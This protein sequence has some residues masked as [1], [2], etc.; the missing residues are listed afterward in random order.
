MPG[1]SVEGGERAS[2]E[3]PRGG[4]AAACE[5]DDVVA[6]RPGVLEDLLLGAL[7]GGPGDLVEA[8]HRLRT[9]GRRQAQVVAHGRRRVPMPAPLLAMVTTSMVAPSASLGQS[10]P[11]GW[12]TGVNEDVDRSR[13]SELQRGPAPWSVGPRSR[14]L[15]EGAAQENEPTVCPGSVRPQKRRRGRSRPRNRLSSDLVSEE[16]RPSLERALRQR[17]SPPASGPDRYA[18]LEVLLE[19]SVE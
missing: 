10:L 8:G 3:C 2:R 12:R 5:R 13:Q 4:S 6:R 14:R 19:V 1:W 15:S 18:S 17:A 16:L 7:E 11:S 9:R